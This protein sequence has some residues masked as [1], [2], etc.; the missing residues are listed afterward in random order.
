M[1]PAIAVS[2]S[3][4]GTSL[5]VGLA[6][7]LQQDVPALQ[8]QR[9]QH[10]VLGLEVVV[11]EPVGDARLVGDVRHAAGVEALAREDA[12]GGVEDQPPLV[13][14]GLLRSRHLRR[15]LGGPAVR[16]GPPVGQRGQRA[17]DLGLALEVELGDDERLGVRRVASTTPH[18]S[19]IIERPP[20]RMPGACSPIWLAATTNAWPSIARARS[21]TSQWSRVVANVNAAG[22]VTISAPLDREDPVELG[23]ADV[24]TDRQAEVGAARRSARARSRR[25]A[26]R[27]RTPCRRARRPRRRTCGSCGSS[28]S[29]RR[30]G[31]RAAIVF[32]PRSSP[33]RARVNEPATRSIAELARDRP[34]PTAGSG[35]RTARRRRS[36]APA[37]RARA[38]SRAARRAPRRRRPPR[39]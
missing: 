26:P 20:E 37:C 13:D 8:E 5:G 3:S 18:G 34:S 23:E 16:L 4:A 21:R 7:R 35:R 30:R 38:T 2:F 10:L 28:P 9:V 22:T 1:K 14:R 15:N 31:R 32:A 25:P 33:R 29:A 12:H 17:A 27:A 19:T 39:G 11:D 6:D 24:V 36:S